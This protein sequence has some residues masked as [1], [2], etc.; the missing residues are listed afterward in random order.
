MVRLP[1]RLRP[2]FPY[3]K[4][5]YV[6]GTRAVAPAAQRISRSGSG[7]LPI[8]SVP[9][10]ELAAAASGGSFTVAREP[11]LL[12]R[13]AMLGRPAGLPL[14]DTSDGDHLG[15]VGVAELPGGRV[16]GRHRA[17]ITAGG[18]LVDEVSRYF[19]TR[20]LRE[21]PLFLNPFPPE[22]LAVPGRL[23]VL[24]VRGDSN[25]Y[26]FLMDVLSRL[27]VLEQA[28]VPAPERWYVPASLPF[29]RELLDLAGIDAAEVVDAGVHPHVRADRLVV[30]GLPANTEKNPPWVVAFL[31]ERLLGPATT[32]PTRRIYVTRGASANNR[33]VRN[34]A[35]VRA[36]LDARGFEAVD[37]GTLPVREQIATFAD[38]A[39]VVATHGAALANLVFCSPGSAVV[40]LFPAGCLLPDYWRL[41]C[42][43]PGLTYRYLS[44]DGRTRTRR[45]ALVRDID[46]D[47]PVLAAVLDELGVR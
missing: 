24:A 41:S 15:R 46:V 35:A 6:A 37:P 47:V 16:L 7:L 36:L 32:P 30:P 5:A 42:G 33:T 21:H 22:P 29:Q 14:S 11:E 1:A 25:Y 13:P 18:E 45:A 40:E 20:R 38:A 26:H 9:T 39:A 8:G 28:G 23:G 34:E 17:V 19:G 31:R 44:S 3:L 12:S 10:L 27:G 43:V 4:P 2:L